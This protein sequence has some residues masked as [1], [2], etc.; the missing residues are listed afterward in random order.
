MKL[1][2]CAT[3]PSP[4]RVRVFM[5]EKAIEIETIQVDLSTGEQFS[6]AFKAINPLG[7]V[8]L[9]Q[10][11]DGTTISQVNAIC[12]Y[13]EEL[14]PD[15]PL[16]GRTPLERALVESANNQAMMNGFMAGAEALRNAVPGMKNRAMPGPHN[17]PQIPALAERGLQRIDNYFSD[18]DAHFESSQ[19]M[20]NDYF[21]VA[22]ISILVFIDFA[23]WVKKRIP[24][25]HK[26]LDRWYQQVS[27]RPSATA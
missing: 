22:D 7:E 21:S 24:E 25:D 17:Y 19:Y 27:Q 14:Y 12:R 8:P 3:A 11:D 9:L 15:N 18:L 4:R 2:D 6:E 10:L 13:L 1:Y 23:K 5:A 26:H 20:V 16:H